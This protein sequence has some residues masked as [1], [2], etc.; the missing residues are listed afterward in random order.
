MSQSDVEQLKAICAQVRNAPKVLS[1]YVL[2]PINYI[3]RRLC[4]RIEIEPSGTA[5]TDGAHLY[6]NPKFIN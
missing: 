2:S 3:L 4:E 6:V 5:A 1:N